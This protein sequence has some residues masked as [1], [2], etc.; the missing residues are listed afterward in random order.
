MEPQQHS[1][2]MQKVL[3]KLGKDLVEYFD[4][5]FVCVTF[6]EGSQTKNAFIK[7]GN[8]YA[9]EGMVGNIHDILFSQESPDVETWEDDED[10]E[11]DGGQKLINKKL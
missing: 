5:G 8:D 11:D 6:Q 7:F 10:D 4:S 3:D 9:I 1:E 2:R